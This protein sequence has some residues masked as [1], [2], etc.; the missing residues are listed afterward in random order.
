MAI[1]EFT[2]KRVEL[3]LDNYCKNKVPMHLRDQIKL[4]Y[5]IRGNNVTLYEE[6]PHFQDPLEWTKSVVAQFRY[7]PNEEIWAIYWKRYTG[8]WYKYDDAEP[9]LNLEVLIEIV[10]RDQLGLFWG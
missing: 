8:K 7:N 6:R 5:E 9:N 10:D 1:N 3:L 4:S 2:K